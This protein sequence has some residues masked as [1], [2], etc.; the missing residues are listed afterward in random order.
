MSELHESSSGEPK[1]AF[2]NHLS[3]IEAISYTSVIGFIAAMA[4]GLFDGMVPWK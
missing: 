1:T 3:L 4:A 2:A